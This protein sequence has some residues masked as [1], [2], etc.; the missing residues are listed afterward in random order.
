MG[1]ALSPQHSNALSRGVNSTGLLRYEC[2]S[3]FFVMTKNFRMKAQPKPPKRRRIEVTIKLESDDSLKRIVEEA[4]RLVSQYGVDL[5]EM[6]FDPECYEFYEG[7]FIGHRDETDEEFEARVK[8]YERRLAG[9]LPT[10]VNGKKLTRS[11]SVSKR[12]RIFWLRRR[13]KLG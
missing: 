8:D 3:P 6:E 2:G 1:Y 11:S 5:D 9:A 4:N 13:A 7:N 10:T 12:K